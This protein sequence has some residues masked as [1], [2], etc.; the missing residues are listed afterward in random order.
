MRKKYREFRNIPNK[1]ICSQFLA[2]CKQLFLK[3]RPRPWTWNLKN[4]DP[5]GW[6]TNQSCYEK[7]HLDV[8]G[9]VGLLAQCFIRGNLTFFEIP[10]E[11]FVLY[12]FISKNR[13]VQDS[14][15]IFLVCIFFPLVSQ[16]C[17]YVFVFDISYFSIAQYLENV[18]IQRSPLLVKSNT[19]TRDV[20][21]SQLFQF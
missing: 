17:S 12:A 14:K 2:M 4:L 16:Y 10:N 9:W 19:Y 5:Q 6:H 15:E 18:C 8:C 3:P 11:S 7:F 21:E 1:N 13:H 20:R